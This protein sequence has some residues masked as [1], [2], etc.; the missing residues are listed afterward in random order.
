MKAAKKDLR[1][2]QIQVQE[3]DKNFGLQEGISLEEGV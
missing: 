1:L 3:T 2:F